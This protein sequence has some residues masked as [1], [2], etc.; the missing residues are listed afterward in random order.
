[1]TDMDIINKAKDLGKGGSTAVTAIVADGQKL[2]VANIGDSRAVL[3]RRGWAVQLSTDHEP[4]VEKEKNSIEDFGGFVSNIPGLV[5]LTP[6]SSYHCFT[7]H[8]LKHL[9]ITMY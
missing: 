1:M 6:L 8:Y 3:C 9:M 2:V 4:S 5:R 7:S